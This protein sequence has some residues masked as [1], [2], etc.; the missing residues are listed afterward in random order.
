VTGLKP[1]GGKFRSKFKQQGS[2]IQEGCREY[3]LK[4]ESEER[5]RKKGKKS[6]RQGVEKRK[7]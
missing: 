4:P 7:D 2:M 3:G 6:K 1:R 5:N